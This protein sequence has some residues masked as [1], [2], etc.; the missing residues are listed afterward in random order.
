MNNLFNSLKFLA[1]LLHQPQNKPIIKLNVTLSGKVL[2]IDDLGKDVCLF[3]DSFKETTGH[4][5]TRCIADRGWSSVVNSRIN[6][7]PELVVLERILQIEVEKSYVNVQK[8]LTS[9]APLRY[10]LFYSNF[11]PK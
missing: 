3:L 7:E 9:L 6:N 4:M 11:P 5:L 8:Y 2:T 10:V 1:T